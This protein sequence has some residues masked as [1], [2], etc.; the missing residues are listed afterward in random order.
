MQTAERPSL[1]SRPIGVFDL[2][3]HSG[4]AGRGGQWRDRRVLLLLFVVS[5]TIVV[6]QA[7]SNND[8]DV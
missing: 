8:E 4:V 5:A 1:A 7:A 6:I 2:G 3:Q